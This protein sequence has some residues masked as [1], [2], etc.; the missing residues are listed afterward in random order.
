MVLRLGGLPPQI[1]LSSHDLAALTMEA[2]ADIWKVTS[3]VTI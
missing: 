2:L 1:Q 3:P